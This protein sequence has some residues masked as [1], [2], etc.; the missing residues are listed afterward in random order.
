MPV[1]LTDTFIEGVS[2]THV[3]ARLSMLALSVVRLVTLASKLHH[4]DTQTHRHTCKLSHMNTCCHLENNS[5]NTGVLFM[6]TATHGLQRV[7]A[8]TLFTR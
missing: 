7:Y 3:V 4:I 5:L 8:R 6:R 1:E 2:Y